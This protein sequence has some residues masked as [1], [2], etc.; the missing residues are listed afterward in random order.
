[1]TVYKAELTSDYTS[2]VVEFSSN[3]TRLAVIRQAKR[4]LNCTGFKMMLITDVGNF[5]QHTSVNF[6]LTITTI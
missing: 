2:K 1:M 4:L 3:G 6:D 5:T